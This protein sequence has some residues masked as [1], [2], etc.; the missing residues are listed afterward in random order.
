MLSSQKVQESPKTAP[1]G[2]SFMGRFLTRGLKNKNKDGAA[3]RRHERY[4][5]TCAGKVSIINSSL[6]LDGIITEIAKGGVKFRPFQNYL[7]E[8]N[9]K[10]VTI[11]I[12]GQVFTGK[13]AATRV[14]GYGIALFEQLSDEEINMLINTNKE[15]LSQAN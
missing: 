6:S 5:C 15:V 9:G 2:R 1:V 3:N 13:I 12:L 11:E 4:E 14:D 8:R 10:E 7:L